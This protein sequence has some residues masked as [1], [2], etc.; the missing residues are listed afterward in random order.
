MIIYS[1]LVIKYV[2]SYSFWDYFCFKTSNWSWARPNPTIQTLEC[3]LIVIWLVS[4]SY[5]E[6]HSQCP[7]KCV[8]RAGGS[9]G[10]LCNARNL[11]VRGQMFNMYYVISKDKCQQ[12]QYWI[13]PSEI[14]QIVVHYYMLTF[15]L[16]FE[17]CW[18]CSIS[19][20]KYKH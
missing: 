18:K 8:R 10:G 14:Y 7:I 2:R 20:Y 3:Y 11:R 13:V 6:S 4:L 16:I 19:Q 15:L 5:C 17:F 12:F 9:R 1:Y